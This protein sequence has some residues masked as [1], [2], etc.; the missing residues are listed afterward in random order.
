MGD[1]RLSSCG[2]GVVHFH[3]GVCIRALDPEQA[4]AAAQEAKP[5][6]NG[7]SEGDAPS[8]A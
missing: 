6:G 3:V 1:S 8:P 2:N 4:S 7:G 5:T